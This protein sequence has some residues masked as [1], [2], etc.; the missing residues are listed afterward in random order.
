MVNVF[1]LH[2]HKYAI[3]FRGRRNQQDRQIDDGADDDADGLLTSSKWEA[4][5]RRE[6]SCSSTSRKDALN[7]ESGRLLVMDQGIN[8]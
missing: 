6:C 5:I 2:L 7:V 4:H 1:A 3:A 8:N